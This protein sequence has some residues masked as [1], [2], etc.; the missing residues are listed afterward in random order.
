MS[1]KSDRL[2]V[3]VCLRKSTCFRGT[4]FIWAANEQ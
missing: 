3:A 1:M 4:V 2:N